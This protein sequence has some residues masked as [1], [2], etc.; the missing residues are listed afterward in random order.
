MVALIPRLK[1]FIEKRPYIF[2]AIGAIILISVAI[3]GLAY[4]MIAL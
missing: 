3:V 2:T 4:Y 1:K